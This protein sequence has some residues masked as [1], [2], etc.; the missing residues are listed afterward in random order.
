MKELFEGRVLHPLTTIVINISNFLNQNVLFLFFG[1]I[2]F[3]LGVYLASRTELFRRKIGEVILK[4]PYFKKILIESALVRFFRSMNMLL[5]GGVPLVDSLRF[6]KK[7]VGNVVL[8]QLI[9]K[10]E[11]E[12]VEG[13]KISQLFSESKFI[14]SLVVRM[15]SI[16]EETGNMA[17]MMKSIAEIYEE[18]LDKDLL[19]LMT[20]LQP[21]VLIFLGAVVGL[22]VLSILLPLTDVSSFVSS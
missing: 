2:F 7:M 1:F 13:R 10:T 18:E 8:A 12:I 20:F 6:S 15:L 21:A 17:A 3:V 11:E 16:G 9:A 5:L 4:T 22:V 14:P 19:Q